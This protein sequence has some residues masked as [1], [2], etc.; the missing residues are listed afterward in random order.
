MEQLDLFSWRPRRRRPARLKGAQEWKIVSVRETAP[1][2]LPLCV[3]PEDAAAY[4]RD[5]I[6]TAPHFNSEVECFAVILVNVKNRVRGHHLVSI[7]ALCETVAQPREVFRAAVIGAAWG[8]LLMHNHPSG[9]PTPSSADLRT[10]KQLQE[11]GRIL[12][13]NMI[14]HVIVGSPGHCSFRAAGLLS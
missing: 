14:D 4:W 7:G 12:Q 3:E 5:H 1:E 6:A 8:V 11:A 9:D 13:I 2:S 10:T